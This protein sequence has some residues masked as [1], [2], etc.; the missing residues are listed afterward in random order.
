MIATPY[1]ICYGGE[2]FAPWVYHIEFPLC[3]ALGFQHVPHYLVDPLQ[4]CVGL[5]IFDRSARG[6]YPKV[7]E[8]WLK[9]PLKFRAIV[10]KHF[11]WT[12]YLNIQTV[13]NILNIQD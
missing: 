5:W 8:Q 12:G 9:I 10:V 1:C 11:L 6:F 2:N 13:S 3:E 4:D 7:F